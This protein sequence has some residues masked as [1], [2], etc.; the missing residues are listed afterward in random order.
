MIGVYDK[1]AI[2]WAYRWLDVKGPHEELPVSQSMDYETFRRQD[3]LVRRTTG[4]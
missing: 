1:F 2:N 4:P 3:V